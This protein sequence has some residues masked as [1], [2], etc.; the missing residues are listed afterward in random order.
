MLPYMEWMA[1]GT[2]WSFICANK[3]PS[4]IARALESWLW[5]VASSSLQKHDDIT[6]YISELEAVGSIE[7]QP[8]LAKRTS[9]CR[10][11]K[12]TCCVACSIPRL[13]ILAL[14]WWARHRRRLP[15]MQ[16]ACVWRSV[17]R[18]RRPRSVAVGWVVVD[19]FHSCSL[20]KRV[21]WGANKN[22]RKPEK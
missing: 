10:M 8:L 21:I 4:F 11:L 12:T 7:M 5:F 2:D 6:S 14:G 19:V 3:V 20:A 18:Q 17:A 1:L 13:V 22:I 15:F 16:C 9:L